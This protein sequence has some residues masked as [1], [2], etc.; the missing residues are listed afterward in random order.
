MEVINIYI[1]IY[2]YIYICVC[3]GGGKKMFREGR[4]DNVGIIWSKSVMYHVGWGGEQNTIYK[5]VETFL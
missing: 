2:I 1:Y 3:V 5:G 4:Q